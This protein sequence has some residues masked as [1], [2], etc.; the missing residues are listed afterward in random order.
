MSTLTVVDRRNISRLIVEAFESFH[1]GNVGEGLEK[2]RNAWIFLSTCQCCTHHRGSRPVSHDSC[3]LTPPDPSGTPGCGCNCRMLMYMISEV[4]QEE[5][6]YSIRPFSDVLPG[7]SGLSHDDFNRFFRICAIMEPEEVHEFLYGADDDATDD[8]TDDDADDAAM[9]PGAPIQ[10]PEEPE[11][12]ESEEPESID[13]SEDNIPQL[14]PR[15]QAWGFL[16]TETVLLVNS[17]LTQDETPAKI[18]RLGDMG[19]DGLPTFASDEVHGRLISS[20]SDVEPVCT[21]FNTSG[22]R[23]LAVLKKYEQGSDLH[24]FR[25]EH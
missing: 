6:Y 13:S 12:L 25:L 18:A 21:W 17:F 14:D 16:P 24:Y 4:N 8:A 19:S 11:E 10:N 9:E 2:L 1:R 23:C 7:F 15:V 5:E 20:E 22:V 3:E